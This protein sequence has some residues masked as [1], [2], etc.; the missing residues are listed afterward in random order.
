[1]DSFGSI[2]PLDFFNDNVCRQ[3]S[4]KNKIQKIWHAIWPPL[5]QQIKNTLSHRDP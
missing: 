1:M 3:C 4:Y 5:S 2:M